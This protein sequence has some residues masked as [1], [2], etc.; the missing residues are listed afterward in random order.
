MS[1]PMRI[2]FLDSSPFCGGAQ[3]SFWSLAEAL[4]TERFQVLLLSADHSNAGLLARAQANGLASQAFFARHW[5]FSGSGLWQFCGDFLRFHSV[6]KQMQDEFQPDLIH[7]NCLRSLLLLSR[8]RCRGVPLLLHDR[9]IRCPALLP[10]L[11]GGRLHMLAAVSGAAAEKWQGLLAPERIRVIANGFSLPPFF[12]AEHVSSPGGTFTLLQVA[13]F[14]AWKNHRLFLQV[15]RSLV[16]RIPGLKGV[17]RGRVRTAAE[18]KLRQQIEQ[19]RQQLGLTEIV[20]I[21][22]S[23]GSAIKELSQADILLSCA[24]AEPFGRVLIEALALGKVVVAVAGGGPSEILAGGQAGSL[25]P[26]QAEA[27]AA[28]VLGWYEQG[29]FRKAATAARAVAE[30]YSLSAHVQAITGLYAELAAEKV[31]SFKP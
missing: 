22:D 14:V 27:L 7:A 13:D 9:D 15:I 1:A 12:P 21:I 23:P 16:G 11:L 24:E 6:L 31:Q 8:R 2:L 17:I 4:P 28:A 5:S 20:E 30:R 18:E 25:C 10:R 29:K 3:E 19:E 26:A